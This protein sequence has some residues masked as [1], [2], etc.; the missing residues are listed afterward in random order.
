[1]TRR[2]HWLFRQLFAACLSCSTWFAPP[3]VAADDS[4]DDA[5]YHALVEEAIQEYEHGNWNEASAAFEQAHAINPNARTLRGMGMAAFE[6]HRYVDSIHRLEEAL[7]EQRHAL[8]SEQRDEVSHVLE[9]AHRYVAHLKLDVEPANVPLTIKI[10]GRASKPDAQRTIV[11]DPGLI[12]VEVSAEGFEPLLRHMAVDAGGEVDLS[13]QLEPARTEEAIAA[14][15]G[16]NELEPG[17]A[18][19][20]ATT[21]HGD[22]GAIPVLKWVS[23]GVAA[24]SL[25]TGAVLLALQKSKASDFDHQCQGFSQLPPNCASIRDEVRGPLWTGPIVAFSVG[26]A[27]A[28]LSAVL[29]IVDAG[30]PDTATALRPACDIG[31]GAIGLQCHARF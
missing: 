6:A 4:N 11:V 21:A 15:R 25:V 22:A 23:G 30:Q 20:A 10:D 13:G 18:T 29:F 7:S 2:F 19:R 27:L 31:P 16:G 9:R 5:R 17:S 26:G 8:T 3:L 1:M 24:A 28:A 12:E 14:A